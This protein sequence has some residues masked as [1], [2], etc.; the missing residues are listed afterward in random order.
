MS[1][2]GPQVNCD[3]EL[4]SERTNKRVQAA[5]IDLAALR[6]RASLRALHFE[7]H[8]QQDPSYAKR[9]VPARSF[10]TKAGPRYVEK[11][12]R[13]RTRRAF[14]TLPSPVRLPCGLPFPP[15]LG[16]RA[17]Q[18]DDDDDDDDDVPDTIDSL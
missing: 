18:L 2:I 17:T 1:R 9:S 5:V 4:G 14:S 6:D 16:H 3:S 12:A 11:N 13:S 10:P 15:A 8:T 7:W